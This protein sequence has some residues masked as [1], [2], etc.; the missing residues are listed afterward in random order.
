MAT[1]EKMS[2][3][4]G[5][6]PA[7]NSPKSTLYPHKKRFDMRRSRG[8]VYQ[9]G[10]GWLERLKMALSWIWANMARCADR[11]KER[12]FSFVSLLPPCLMEQGEARQ[13]PILR[14]RHRH[15]RI[16][17]PTAPACLSVPWSVCFVRF[18][19]E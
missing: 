19:Q 2:S 14:G 18:F 5:G 4:A 16:V 9:R 8:P 17:P 3:E 1:I 13:K 11:G 7:G 10:R 15:R 6:R 12:W